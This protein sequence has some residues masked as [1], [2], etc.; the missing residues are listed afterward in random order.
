M[1]KTY[2]I[3]FSKNH[4]VEDIIANFKKRIDDFNTR[5]NHILAFLIHQGIYK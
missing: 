5:M 1:K 3:D 4:R 2:Y